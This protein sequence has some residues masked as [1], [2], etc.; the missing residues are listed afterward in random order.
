MIDVGDVKAVLRSLGQT[1]TEAELAQMA[2]HV[3]EDGKVN[4]QTFTS[5]VSSNKKSVNP[6]KF[7]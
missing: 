6:G 2:T 4:F 5:M 7:T 3:G 1:P